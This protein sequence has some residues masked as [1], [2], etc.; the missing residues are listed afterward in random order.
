VYLA[1]DILEKGTRF[2]NSNE[3]R[4]DSRAMRAKTGFCAKPFNILVLAK[5]GKK[6]TPYLRRRPQKGGET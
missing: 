6:T 3:L 2:A 5:K 4:L 1:E